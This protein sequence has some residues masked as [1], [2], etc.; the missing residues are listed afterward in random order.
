MIKLTKLQPPQTLIDKLL[1][2]TERLL[3]LVAE[4]R[5][6]PDSLRDS[7]RDPEV[8]DLIRRETHDKCIYCESKI[9]HVYH[10][11]VEH[12]LPKARFPE[13]TLDYENLG[14]AC[15]I[16]NNRKGDVHDDGMP[17]INPYKDNTED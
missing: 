12:I 9:S 13:L 6:V 1:V 3:A 11:D 4:G 15:A 16:C 8:K 2:K 17:L 5:E 10:G 7:Y 14:L